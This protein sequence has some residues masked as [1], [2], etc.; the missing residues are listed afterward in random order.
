MRRK[1]YEI[2][3]DARAF[4]WLT[5]DTA[6][7][8]ITMNFKQKNMWKKPSMSYQLRMLEKMNKQAWRFWNPLYDTCIIW[9][10]D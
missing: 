1:L 7:K 3:Q 2:T 5:Q 4:Q 9:N 6:I 8:L 10:N